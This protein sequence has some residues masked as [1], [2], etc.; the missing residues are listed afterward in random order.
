MVASTAQST[1]FC[2]A[3]LSIILYILEKTSWIFFFLQE[4]FFWVQITKS[5]FQKNEFIEARHLIFSRKNNS[6]S[7][8]IFRNNLS[9]GS[10]SSSW[11]KIW[12]FF[13]TKRQAF[14]NTVLLSSAH[15]HTFSRKNEFQICMY[16]HFFLNHNE[17]WLF[18]YFLVCIGFWI[19]RKKYVVGRSS[20]ISV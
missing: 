15:H 12:I 9:N 8:F 4:Q 7:I 1:C 14:Q 20:N 17:S 16:S 19:F 3:W 2:K 13:S 11:E 10:N 6:N 5:S 18:I